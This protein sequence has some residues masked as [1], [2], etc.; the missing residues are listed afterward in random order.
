[1]KFN[2]KITID[3]EDF[4]RTGKFDYLQLGKTKE[5]VLN[6]FP[7]PDGMEDDKETIDRD[8]WFYGNL[9]LH[10]EEDKLFLIYSDYITELSGGEQLELKKSFLENID[11]LKLIDI[12]SQLNKLHIDF[13]KKRL[14][15]SQKN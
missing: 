7:D 3:F 4:F 13:I 9:E 6:N 1:M 8:I 11:E 15:L 2:H 10:F 14:K 12:L 5:W